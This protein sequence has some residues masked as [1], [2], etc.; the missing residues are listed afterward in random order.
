M[1]LIILTGML[2]VAQVNIVIRQH[3][4]RVSLHKV[5]VSPRILMR[6]L[7]EAV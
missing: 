2:R 5:R 1:V 3:V 7:L 4:F 6:I